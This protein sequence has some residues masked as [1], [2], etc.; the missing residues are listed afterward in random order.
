MRPA[1]AHAA[2]SAQ[3]TPA[4]ALDGER[5]WGETKYSSRLRLV[6]EREGWKVDDIEYGGDWQFMHK[7]RLRELLEDVVRESRSPW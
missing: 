6:Q 5:E 4:E 2:E 1:A 3:G 7:G